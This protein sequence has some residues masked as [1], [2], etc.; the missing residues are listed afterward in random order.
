MALFKVSKGL[1]ANLPST[2]T[3]GYAYFCTDD[4]S[5]WIDYK[6]GNGILQRKQIDA[7]TVS[8]YTVAIDVPADAKFTDTTYSVVTTSENGLM[9]YSD[10]T[11]LDG[12]VAITN[13]EIDTI[14]GATIYAASEVSV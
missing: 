10:K 8:G 1:K 13:D 14:C 12:M 6:D 2:K 3:D 4:G 5:F 9:S 11:K 7:G